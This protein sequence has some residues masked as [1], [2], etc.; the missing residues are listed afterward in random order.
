MKSLRWIVFALLALLVLLGFGLRHHALDPERE[1]RGE[2]MVHCAAGLQNPL[3]AIAAQYEAASDLHPRIRFNFSGSGALESQIK[4]VGGDLFIPADASYI[5]RCQAAGVVLDAIPIAGLRAVI[6]VQKGNP[7]RLESIDDL[8]QA[9]LRLSMAEPSAAMGKVVRETLQASGDWAELKPQVI[10]TKPTVNSVIEDVATR[11]VDA[12]IA[13]DA[14]ALAYDQEVDLIRV[15]LFDVNPRDAMVGRLKDA[16][17]PAAREFMQYLVSE[18][19]G[20]AIF[21]AHGF[22]APTARVYERRGLDTKQGSTE[23]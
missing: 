13:W 22:A 17:M 20:Q 1:A 7:L 6:V 23:P 2:L 12:T 3:R 8:K 15:P 19:K 10:V 4:L 14:V 16:R 9:S 18:E 5:E 11:A 21:R